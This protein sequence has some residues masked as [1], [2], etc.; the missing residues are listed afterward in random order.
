MSKRHFEEQKKY[1][2][3]EG[4][5]PKSTVQKQQEVESIHLFIRSFD[6]FTL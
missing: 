5:A 3:W 2:S 6:V 4:K 1:S